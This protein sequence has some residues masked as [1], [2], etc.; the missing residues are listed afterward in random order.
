[1]MKKRYVIE[2]LDGKFKSVVA[3]HD[4]LSGVTGAYYFWD[5]IEVEGNTA[6]E[7]YLS[8]DCKLIVNFSHVAWISILEEPRH[9]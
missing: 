5:D 9:G 7:T 6:G 3:E 2:L 8:R 1:M 4:E